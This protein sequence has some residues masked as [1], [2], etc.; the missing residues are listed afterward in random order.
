M[1]R[2]AH[3][4]PNADGA[5]CAVRTNDIGDGLQNVIITVSPVTTHAKGFRYRQR[6]VIAA[7]LSEGIRVKLASRRDYCSSTTCK[8]LV[9]SERFTLT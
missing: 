5:A 3:R 8:D 1:L 2:N 7:P 9:C 6:T 4:S